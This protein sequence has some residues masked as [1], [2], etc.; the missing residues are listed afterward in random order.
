[1]LDGNGRE[2]EGEAESRII[3]FGKYQGMLIE[4]D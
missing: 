3:M 1:M 2:K 4:L